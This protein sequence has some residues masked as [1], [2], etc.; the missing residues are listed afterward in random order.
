[1]FD[2]VRL[3][4]LHVKRDYI[5]LLYTFHGEKFIYDMVKLIVMFL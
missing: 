1:M 2:T 4:G 5:S 3:I